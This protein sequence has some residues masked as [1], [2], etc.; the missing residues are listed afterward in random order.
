MLLQEALPYHYILLKKMVTVTV[1]KLKLDT[2]NCDLTTRG[3]CVAPQGVL[4]TILKAE[5]KWVNVAGTLGWSSLLIHIT[6]EN[7]HT[8][9]SARV[10][11]VNSKPC[12]ILASGPTAESSTL[13]CQGIAINNQCPTVL[14]FWA[15]NT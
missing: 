3:Q 2:S 13:E 12:I 14:C 11:Q 15:V 8:R 6:I 5:T 7:S 10:Q 4:C 9:D 1:S